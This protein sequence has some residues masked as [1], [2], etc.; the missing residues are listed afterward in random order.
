MIQRDYSIETWSQ[1]KNRNPLA[2]IHMNMIIYFSQPTC[3]DQNN[4]FNTQ[5]NPIASQNIH[6]GRDTMLKIGKF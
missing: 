3:I 2:R 6:D 4:T 1:T 5:D